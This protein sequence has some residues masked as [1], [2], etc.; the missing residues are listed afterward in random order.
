MDGDVAGEAT[1]DEVVRFLR[2]RGYHEA[3]DALDRA[4]TSERDAAS[5]LGESDAAPLQTHRPAAAVTLSQ[6]P[7]ATGDLQKPPG[8]SSSSKRHG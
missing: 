1:L 7:P 8:I 2:G 3:L 6:V 5:T 4:I